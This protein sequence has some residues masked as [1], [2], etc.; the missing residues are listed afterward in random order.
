MNIKIIAILVM[1]LA[2]CSPPRTRAEALKVADAFMAS[3]DPRMA[4]RDARIVKTNSGWI[5]TYLLMR[6]RAERSCDV[7]VA[8]DTM[9]VVQ[10]L[11]SQ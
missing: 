9:S 3:E 5:V 4:S 8:Y 10:R 2:G 1:A 11:C 7:F 6:G